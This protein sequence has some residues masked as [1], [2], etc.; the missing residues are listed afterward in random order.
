M[1]NCF[2]EDGPYFA[3]E[4][5]E[6]KQGYLDIKKRGAKVR[7]ITRVTKNNIQHC[8]NLE[9]IVDEVRQPDNVEEGIA[10]SD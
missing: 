6:Y 5:P 1:D 8:K 2:N 9:K 3:M 10:I 4:I 7:V